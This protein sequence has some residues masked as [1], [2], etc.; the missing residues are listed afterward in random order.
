M[1]TYYNID[2]K[3]PVLL[4]MDS[5]APTGWDGTALGTADSTSTQ[6]GAFYVYGSRYEI[7]YVPIW[8]SWTPEDFQQ[9]NGP[10]IFQ[11]PE[12]KRAF[13][14]E[15]TLSYWAYGDGTT[16]D[17]GD[18]TFT[19]GGM[20]DFRF[21]TTD[22]PLDTTASIWVPTNWIHTVGLDPANPGAISTTDIS[23]LSPLGR[24]LFP[25]ESVDLRVLPHDGPLN[26]ASARYC[27]YL[28]DWDGTSF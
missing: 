28:E 6:N 27:G 11:C 13:F 16:M 8:D 23:I 10:A 14:T 2:K 15:A 4:A 5:T 17:W 1:A 3:P 21:F 25:G 24:P 20:A 12:G 22:G 7:P 19:M 26:Y 18:T 9:F